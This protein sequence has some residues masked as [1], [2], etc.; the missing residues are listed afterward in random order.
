M[1]TSAMSNSKPFYNNECKCSEKC[2]AGQKNRFEVCEKVIL[3]TISKI[4]VVIY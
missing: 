4:K 1:C 2:G 3:E